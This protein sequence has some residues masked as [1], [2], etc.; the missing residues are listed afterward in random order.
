MT[1]LQPPLLAPPDPRDRVPECPYVGLVPFDEAH[2][3][4]FFGRERERDLIMANLTASRFTSLY[5]P[6]GVG[7]SSVLRAGVVPEHRRRAEESYDDF[8]TA[9]VAVAYVSDWSGPASE[10]IARTIL[11]ALAQTPGASRVTPRH[12]AT[13]RVAEGQ[14]LGDRTIDIFHLAAPDVQIRATN[15]GP[16]EFDEQSPGLWVWHWIVTQLKISTIGA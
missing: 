12:A 3:G 8:G 9:G 4:Y 15:A 14:I 6:S 1:T 7:K 2:E 11:H 5:A 10:M 16:R 13:E